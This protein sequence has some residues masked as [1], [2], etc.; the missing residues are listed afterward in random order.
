MVGAA[1]MN[2]QVEETCEQGGHGA[3]SDLV[4]R[5]RNITVDRNM[6][7]KNRAMVLEHREPIVQSLARGYSW[8]AV[9]QALFD[10]GDITMSYDAFRYQ[11]R[12]VG[13]RDFEPGY[14]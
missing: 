3:V 7:G 4:D 8:K 11:C 10:A 9:W 13:I 1:G 2:G 5:V 6:R 12:A 14:E